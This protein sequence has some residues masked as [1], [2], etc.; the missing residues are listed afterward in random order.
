M[1]VIMIKTYLISALSIDGFIAKDLASPST[2]WTSKED[3]KM[4]QKI[5][6]DLRVVVMGGKTYR[7]FNQ[8]LKG[9]INIIYTRDQ[10]K[11]KSFD[12]EKINIEDKTSLYYTDLKPKDLVNFFDKKGF[13]NIAICGGQNIYSWFA[14]E[15]LVDYLYLTVEN[16]VFGQGLKLF[17]CDLNLK[18]KLINKENLNDSTLLLKYE[19][20][21]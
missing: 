15:G 1:K 11:L 18:T 6:K 8:P 17:N 2:A 10:E 9:R 7:T 19:V 16:I 21:K 4:F 14:R 5:T 12:I 13:Q 3:K 20:L